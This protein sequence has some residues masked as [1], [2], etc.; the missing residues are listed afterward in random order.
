VPLVDAS[1]SQILASV[2]HTTSQEELFLAA[3]V[4]LDEPFRRKVQ[5]DTV[6]LLLKAQQLGV[7]RLRP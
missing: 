3:G 4:T 7:A 6:K 2:G 1:V 5:A